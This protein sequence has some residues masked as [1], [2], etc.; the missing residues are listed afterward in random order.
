MIIFLKMAC[1]GL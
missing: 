1:S